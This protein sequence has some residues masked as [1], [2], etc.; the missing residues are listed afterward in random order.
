MPF[1]A[2]SSWASTHASKT[3]TIT[4]WSWV[5]NDPLAVAN[6][7]KHY[8][9]IKVKYD[10]VGS[11]ATEYTKLRTVLE[12]GSGAP[13]VVQIEYDELPAFIGIHKLDNIASY[14][15]KYKS[16]YPSWVWDQV[17]QDGAVYAVPEDIGPMGL[18]YNPALLAKY[19]LAKPT[20][21]AIFEADAKKLHQEAPGEYMIASP[22]GITSGG[23]PLVSMFMQAGATLFHE[24]SNGTW[25]VSID[26]ATT[27]K[28][29]Q[30]WVNLD[31]TGGVDPYN[32]SS[33]TY[34]HNI[35]LAKYVSYFGA[36]WEPALLSPYVTTSTPQQFAVM[37]LPQW[38][39][40][41]DASANWGGSSN[42]VT[43]QTPASLEKDAALFAAFINTSKSG[44][45]NTFTPYIS[46]GK[47]G[48]GDFPATNLRTTVPAYNAKL[49]DF[50]PHTWATFSSFASHVNTKFEWS[51]W[52]YTLFSDLATQANK[53]AEGKISVANALS[54][55]Q[56][57]IV[58]DAKQGGYSVKVVS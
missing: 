53:A 6:F 3:V 38:V 39:A 42:A 13:D 12:A 26:S 23:G 19:K 43:D 34:D 55:A 10:D 57:E 18:I 40:G 31:K 35:G 9:N 1:G 54:A 41:Q 58:T 50:P 2:G 44:V 29:L 5:P 21:W 16:D 20:T 52:A 32:E 11:G 30:Y 48:R 15:G 56:Q 45:E 49:V 22:T 17:S 51:P 47:G 24:E 46:N 28:V 4:W 8:P 7:E 27:R 25:E 14:V 36:A 37:Q 33:V